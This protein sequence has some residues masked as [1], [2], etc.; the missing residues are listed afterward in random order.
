MIL[1]LH[2]LTIFLATSEPSL[3][4]RFVLPSVS[5][6]KR[7]SSRMK[8]LRSSFMKFKRSIGSLDGSRVQLEGFGDRG[9]VV[10]GSFVEVQ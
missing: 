3:P 1:V 8:L 10:V 7:Q 9:R 4:P 5:W 6:K 2:T